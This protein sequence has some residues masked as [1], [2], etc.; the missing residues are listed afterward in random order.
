MRKTM[1]LVI[2]GVALAFIGA[3]IALYYAMILR[4]EV[5]TAEAEVEEIKNMADLSV[6][7]NNAANENSEVPQGTQSEIEPRP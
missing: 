2:A 7:L 4:K 3:S 1:W 5:D 6:K